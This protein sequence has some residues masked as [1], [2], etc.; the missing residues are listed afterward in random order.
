MVCDSEG[1]TYRV[2]I[3]ASVL[4]LDNMDDDFVMN[5]DTVICKAF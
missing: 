5:N 2:H 1:R 3:P 4:D